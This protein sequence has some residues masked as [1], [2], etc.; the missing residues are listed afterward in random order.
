MNFS[1]S[2]IFIFTTMVAIFCAIATFETKE[3]F[4]KFYYAFLFSVN[5]FSL[6]KLTQNK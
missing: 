5:I 6:F 2:I 1:K 3:M 4:L